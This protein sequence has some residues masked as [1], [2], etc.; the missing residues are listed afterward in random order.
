MS[1]RDQLL[2]LATVVV[3]SLTVGMQAQDTQHC[4]NATLHGSYGFH[5]TGTRFVAIGRFVF[6]EMVVSPESSSSGCRARILGLSNFLE[7]IR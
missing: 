5:A 2:Q 4:S 1:F 6:D 7:R 3:L